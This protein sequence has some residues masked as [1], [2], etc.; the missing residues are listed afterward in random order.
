[1]QNPI[2]S[3]VLLTVLQALGLVVLEAVLAFFADAANLQG[4]V[5]PTSGALI[6]AVALALENAIYN[7]TGKSLLGTV[8]L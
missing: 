1:M 3:G 4:L 8:N 2:S 6:A 5:N 7:K